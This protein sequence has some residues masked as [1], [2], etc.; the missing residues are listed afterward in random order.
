MAT[1]TVV[2]NFAETILEWDTAKN[3][4]TTHKFTM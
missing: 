4:V 2:L 3:I 1:E